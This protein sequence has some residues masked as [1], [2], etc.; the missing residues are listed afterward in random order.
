MSSLRLPGEFMAGMRFI[1]I[2]Y[3][4]IVKPGTS[5]FA[6]QPLRAGRHYLPVMLF[7]LMWRTSV[8]SLEGNLTVQWSQFVMPAVSLK[9]NPI[10]QRHICLFSNPW[11]GEDY[12]FNQSSLRPFLI[13]GISLDL[14]FSQNALI[15]RGC[16]EECRRWKYAIRALTHFGAVE[17]LIALSICQQR[18]FF[19]GMACSLQQD[20]TQ[21]SSYRFLLFFFSL[22]LLTGQRKLI[23]H[24]RKGWQGKNSLFSTTPFFKTFLILWDKRQCAF[25]SCQSIVLKLAA[26]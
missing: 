16:R 4:F 10:S 26:D 2:I 19:D 3:L 21:A 25:I 6:A 18:K 12:S 5:G 13:R 23:F 15:F 22:P 9:C 20:H 1:I 8:I 14:T 11:H 24:L 7:V 17:K